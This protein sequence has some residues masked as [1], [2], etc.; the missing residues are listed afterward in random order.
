MTRVLRVKHIFH[1]DNFILLWNIHFYQLNDINEFGFFEAFCFSKNT[2]GL[3]TICVTKIC[4]WKWAWFDIQRTEIESIL[5][6][7]IVLD[8]FASVTDGKKFIS[9]DCLT[10]FELCRFVHN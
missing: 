3:Y 9:E 5:G 10:L 7:H 4:K 1:K 2:I 6:L 8:D